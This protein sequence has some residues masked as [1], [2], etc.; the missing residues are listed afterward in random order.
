MNDKKDSGEIILYQPDS[1]VQVEVRLDD[2]T[3]WLTQQQMVTLFETTK[4]N[5][6]LHIRNII[7]EGELDE[8]ST[9]KD[10]LTVRQE[11]LRAVQR[12]VTYYNLDMIISVGFRI[13]SQRGILFRQWATQ[14]LKEHLLRGYTINQRLTNL[15]KQVSRHEEKIEFFVRTALPP[16][17]GIF[18]DGQIFDAYHFV[19]DL[20]RRA[21]QSI[22]LIDNYV[23]ESVLLLL[24]KRKPGVS[25]TLYTSHFTPQLQH[26][27]RMHNTQY[28]PIIIASFKRSH[29]R[30]LLI[31]DDVYH[32]GASLKDLGKKWFAFSH[33][34]IRAT[35]LLGMLT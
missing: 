22:V 34:K 7:K 31:D 25:A 1:S 5:V 30:F 32:I 14:V 3:V 4:Q 9:V 27:L 18:F 10:Y 12:T 6:S 28:P 35:E 21:E 23:D 15:E 29:D 17:E 24:S 19:A 20:I 8:N 33:L 11:G 2:E 13:K 26:D 16:S